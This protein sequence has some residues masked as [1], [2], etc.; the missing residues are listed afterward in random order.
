M[1]ELFCLFKHPR[2]ECRSK[3]HSYI[4]YII[5]E[6]HLREIYGLEITFKYIET[7]TEMVYLGFNLSVAPNTYFKENDVIIPIRDFI[8]VTYRKEFHE[9]SA[10]VAKN[11]FDKKF[12]MNPHLHKYILSKMKNAQL[13]IHDRYTYEMIRNLS[14]HVEAVNTNPIPGCEVDPN[15]KAYIRSKLTIS[16]T[17]IKENV[18]KTTYKTNR[19]YTDKTTDNPIELNSEDMKDTSL[20][21]SVLLSRAEFGIHSITNETNSITETNRLVPNAMFFPNIGLVA[22]QKISNPSTI[23]VFG[24]STGFDKNTNDYETMYD[25]NVIVEPKEIVQPYNQQPQSLMSNQILVR[26]AMRS[27]CISSRR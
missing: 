24:H 9:S 1:D 25:E 8:D 15:Q 6:K 17:F 21:F 10:S 16:E 2:E 5:C 18:L 14:S 3:K 23:V 12:R 11:D 20:I 27:S 4:R 13:D 26:K 22:M 19:Y 7:P